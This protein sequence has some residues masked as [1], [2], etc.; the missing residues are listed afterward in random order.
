M[1]AINLEQI[2]A[3]GD[4]QLQVGN[5]QEGLHPLGVPRWT[6]AH[7]QNGCT[8]ELVNDFG[9]QCPG[10]IHPPDSTFGPILP[11]CILLRREELGT[12][13]ILR[14]CKA[15]SCWLHIE[16]L[17]DVLIPLPAN[18][19]LLRFVLL[20]LRPSL[21]AR[22]TSCCSSTLRMSIFSGFCVVCRG[23]Q[24]VHHVGSGP[25]PPPLSPPGIGA[26]EGLHLGDLHCH[27]FVLRLNF[28]L[29]IVLPHC[30]LN[31]FEICA[32]QAKD[33]V[34]HRNPAKQEVQ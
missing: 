28:C 19:I 30:S 12:S 14:R 3:L 9:P 32:A 29:K 1:L 22:W 10:W 18:C 4:V 17:A 13:C 6:N 27:H 7:R 31:S 8:H 34:C 5:V 21:P 11:K 16:L 15:I 24:L 26:L 20:R 23:A 2:R 25:A 33:N